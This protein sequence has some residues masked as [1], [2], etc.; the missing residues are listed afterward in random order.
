MSL[1]GEPSRTTIAREGLSRGC[2]TAREIIAA[3]EPYTFKI[4]EALVI[5]DIGAGSCQSRKG[6]AS[7]LRTK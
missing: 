3:G 2:H 6:L 1:V 4:K 7:D 5:P